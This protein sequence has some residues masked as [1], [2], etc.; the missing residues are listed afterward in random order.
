MFKRIVSTALVATLTLGAVYMSYTS[1]GNNTNV[2]ETERV[3]EL[4]VVQDEE[5]D[6]QCSDSEVDQEVV[7]SD[8]SDT[9]AGDNVIST[10]SKP[11]NS[12]SSN[13][14]E[15]TNVDVG[16]LDSA[17]VDLTEVI[18]DEI[19]TNEI[20]IL[21]AGVSDETEKDILQWEERND[22]SSTDI[23]ARYDETGFKR[24]ANVTDT[25][26]EVDVAADYRIVANTVDGEKIGSNVVTLVKSE[27]GYL[28]EDVIDTDEDDIPDGYE[29][30]IG[31]NANVK[32]TD[33]DGF[34][35]GYEVFVLCTNPIVIDE[36]DDFDGDGLRNLEEIATGT[37]PYLKDSDFDGINDNKDVEPLK[38]NVDTGMEVD[39]TIPV[40]TGMFDLVSTYTDENGNNCELVYNYLNGQIKYISDSENERYSVYNEDNQL[41]AAV[42]YVD[43]KIIANTYSYKD[44]NIE[45]ITHNGFQYAFSYDENGNM[46][47]VKVG[48]RTLIT[49]QYDEDVL[50]SETYGNGHTNEFVYDEYGNVISQKS[51]GITVYEW[52]YDEEGNIITHKDVLADEQY[53]YT[54][55]ENGNLT[56]IRSD[57]GFYIGYEES[58]NAYSISYEYAETTK[59]Q[60]TT[61]TEETDE[62]GD[63]IKNITTTN[64]ISGGKLVTVISEEDTTEKTLYVN[65]TALLNSKYTI[66]DKGIIQIE[67][68][69]GKILE[70]DYD[71]IGNIVSV[72]ENGELKLSYEYDS[73]GQLVRENNLYAGKSYTYTYDNAGNILES[74]EYAYSTEGLT[75]VE[76]VKTYEYNDNGWRDLLTS[77]NGQAI[78]YD[79][80]GNPLTYRDGMIFS[81]AGR[82]LCTVNIGEDVISYTYNSNGIRTSKT[83]NGITT[84]YQL[85]DAKIVAE[86]T[87]NITIWYVYDNDDKI[88]GFEYGGQTYYFE[89][90]VQGDVIKIYDESGTVVSEYIY[91]AWGN[92]VAVYGDKDIA[93]VNPFRYRG[94]YQD[95]E[96]GFYYLQSRYYDSQTKRFLSADSFISLSYSN[97]YAYVVNNP[98]NMYDPSGKAVD[99]ILDVAWAIGSL[100]EFFITPS[101]S[102]FGFLAWDVAAI[103]VPF[104]P[105]SYVDDAGKC[106]IK[107]ANRISDFKNSNCMTLGA[108]NKLK[109]LFKGVED[110]EIHHIIEKRFLEIKNGGKKVFK[111]LTQGKMM[112]IPLSHQLHN[113]ITQRWRSYFPYGYNYNTITKEKMRNAIKYVYRDMPKLK[114]VALDYLDEVWK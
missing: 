78:T 95:N 64:L 3:D 85:D 53:S 48:E 12:V 34:T 28:Y 65:E 54:Y 49:N 4:Y 102:T 20:Y 1:D 70:Y 109:K 63:I 71:E 11:Q 60:T 72:T 66:F 84:I 5:I 114:E 108:Y 77:F 10:N 31:T 52:Q 24:I 61:Q 82:Q 21:S 79:E 101:W 47:N 25:E 92:I 26:Y 68:Q 90:S 44:R 111:D 62:N 67:Y 16:T 100:V 29:Y 73:L 36:N 51:N 86:T 91:D 9:L 81:W 32:D 74:K 45:T 19:K 33:N 6:L 106:V 76:S 107:V 27:D 7:K 40:K 69:D 22:I 58:E 89:K 14:K 94:Y 99:I 57:S 104:V 96:T 112:S 50:Q 88:I 87:E 110:V 75:E 105:G 30:L 23:Y 42:E 93:K 98:T 59:T 15:T 2:V 55:D 46:T 13:E 103:F 18:E 17:I 41:V 35:D 39:Y 37:N 8:D 43:E 113:T 83:V 56:G 80:I 38:T 97:L